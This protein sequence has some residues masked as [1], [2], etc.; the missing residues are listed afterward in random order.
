MKEYMGREENG[1]MEY[2]GDMFKDVRRPVFL[3]AWHLSEEGNESVA[4]KLVPLIGP[5]MKG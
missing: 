5:L 4:K 3:D 2:L 1:D